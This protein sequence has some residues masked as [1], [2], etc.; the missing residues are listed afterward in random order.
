VVK[1][2]AWQGST[3]NE[4]DRLADPAAKSAGSDWDLPSPHLASL[5]VARSDIDAYEHVNNAIYMSWFD[6]AAWDHSA[7]LGLPIEKC[8]QLD[9]GMA[10][11]RSV[12]AYLRPAVL[13]DTVQLAT[14][15]LPADGKLRVRRR[16]QVRR[17]AD[18]ATLAR[19]EIEYACLEL[20]SG[21]PVR[22]PP[23]FRERYVALEEVLRTVETLA[24]V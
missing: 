24:P 9:R 20:S 17:D 7:A 6:R 16:F 4:N 2:G 14:W 13:G 15:L 21:R 23:E 5:A 10:V 12:I 18:R 1:P 11:V 22:W 19:A 3:V 8:L